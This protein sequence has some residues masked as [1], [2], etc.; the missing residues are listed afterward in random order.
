MPHE[1][2][3]RA[4]ALDERKY[5]GFYTQFARARQIRALGWADEMLEIADDASADYTVQVGDGGGSKLVP[6]HEHIQRARLQNN[7]VANHSVG[8][9]FHR[10]GMNIALRVRWALSRAALPA[11]VTPERTRASSVITLP[12]LCVP[13]KIAL[14]SRRGRR[15]LRGE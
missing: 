8:G 9:L 14:A 4:W 2:T 5:P 15:K 11:L 12:R 10:A 13:G 3:V 7:L 6:D 1:A